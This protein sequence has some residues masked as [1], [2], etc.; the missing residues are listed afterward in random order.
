[1]KGIGLSMDKYSEKTFAQK[2]KAPTVRDTE[3]V[4]AFG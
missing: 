2:Q 3:S 4:G 1:M